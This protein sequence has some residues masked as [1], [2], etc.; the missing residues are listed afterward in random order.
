MC[1]VKK[2][3]TTHL[4]VIFVPNRKDSIVTDVPTFKIEDPSQLAVAVSAIFPRKLDDSY[5]VSIL[6]WTQGRG[7][8]LCASNLPQHFACP[9]L[10]NVKPHPCGSHAFSPARR[11]QKFPEAATLRISI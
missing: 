5:P 8:P 11:A 4:K 1:S 10:G 3:F 6:V 9:T 2:G 7:I